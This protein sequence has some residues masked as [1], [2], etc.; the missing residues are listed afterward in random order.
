[1]AHT[2]YGSTPLPRAIGF[3]LGVFVVS[4]MPS[5]VVSVVDYVTA[6][7][8]CFDHKL[9]YVVWPWIEAIAFTS[10]AIDP[11]I[12]CFRNCEFQDGLRRNFRWCPCLHSRVTPEPS[13]ESGWGRRLQ[14]VQ[15]SEVLTI[16]VINETDIG[17]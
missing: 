17:E 12:Y 11:W 2:V 4:W 9:V 10:S 8:K 14:T 16:Q 6:N 15:N 1:M 5:I 7:D 13:L 3:V